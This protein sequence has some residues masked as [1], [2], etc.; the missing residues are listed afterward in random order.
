MH[1]ALDSKAGTTVHLL[2]KWVQLLCFVEYNICPLSST[3]VVYTKSGVTESLLAPC[4]QSH[5][6]G[7]LC[8]VALALAF[9][10]SSV[11]F[12]GDLDTLASLH[13]LRYLRIGWVARL[14]IVFGEVGECK[15]GHGSF[16]VGEVFRVLSA[17]WREFKCGKLQRL[18]DTILANELDEPQEEKM[19]EDIRLGI[20]NLFSV[21]QYSN[22]KG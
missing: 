15:K 3:V 14:L 8:L 6:R 4:H 13:E 16:K 12:L 2:Q 19:E 20:K 1:H 11:E 22:N 10:D 18:V 5:E 7:Q 9:K 21:S 17:K